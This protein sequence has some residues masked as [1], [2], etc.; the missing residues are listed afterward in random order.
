MVNDTQTTTT[1]VKTM[2]SETLLESLY[3]ALE[4]NKSDVL[5]EV[6]DEL[7]VKGYENDYLIE[8][9]KKKIGPNAVVILK[10]ALGIAGDAKS[11]AGATPQEQNVKEQLK[12]IK[13]AKQDKGILSRIKNIFK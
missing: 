5:M 9:V 11:S 2:W 7:K 1:E 12:K 4:K 6:L 3:V 13:E 10:N 8:K